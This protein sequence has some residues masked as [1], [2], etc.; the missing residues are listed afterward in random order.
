MWPVGLRITAWQQV[1]S[2]KDEKSV[3]SPTILMS[4]HKTHDPTCSQN[5]VRNDNLHVFTLNFKIWYT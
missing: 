5:S 4:H 3:T 1:E 2:E